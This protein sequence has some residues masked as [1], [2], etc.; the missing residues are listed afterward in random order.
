MK[1]H[2]RINTLISFEE[3]QRNKLFMGSLLLQEILSSSQLWCCRY[4]CYGCI[5]LENS[6]NKK[7]KVGEKKLEGKDSFLIQ[8]FLFLLLVNG[9]IKNILSRVITRL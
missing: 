3:N 2:V 6:I 4:N 1:I 9:S 8:L 5:S 7:E